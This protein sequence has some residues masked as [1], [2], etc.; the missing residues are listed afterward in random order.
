M[1]IIPDYKREGLAYGLGWGK[2]HLRENIR[3]NKFIMCVLKEVGELPSFVV[4]VENTDDYYDG[5]PVLQYYEVGAPF[6]IRVTHKDY[7]IYREDRGYNDKGSWDFPASLLTE[8]ER[9]PRHPDMTTARWN[10]ICKICG[11][12]HKARSIWDIQYV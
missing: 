11:A 10:A 3:I 1:N 4:R 9:T 12:F 2:R 8:E 7:Y 6:A 5:R